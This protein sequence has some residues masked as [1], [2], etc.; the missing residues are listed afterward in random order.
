MGLHGLLQGCGIT[1]IYTQRRVMWDVF[2]DVSEESFA[3]VLMMEITETALS[4][5][6]AAVYH[7]TRDHSP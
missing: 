6:T 3:S 2:R 4:S 5:E 7:T 1:S